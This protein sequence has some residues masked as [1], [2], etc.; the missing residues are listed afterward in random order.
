M[1]DLTKKLSQYMKPGTYKKGENITINLAQFDGLIIVDKGICLVETSRES[2][3]ARGKYDVSVGVLKPEGSM[4]GLEFFFVPQTLRYPASVRSVTDSDVRTMT[5]KKFASLLDT[6]LASIKTFIFEEIARQLADYFN[7]LQL[8]LE[9]Q[10]KAAPE[11]R[12]L[13]VFEH[14]RPIVGTPHPAG[15]EIKIPTYVL[16]RLAGDSPRSFQEG[17]KRLMQEGKLLKSGRASW[18][19]PTHN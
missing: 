9:R 12:V 18:V 10:A 11:D 1:S 7:S 3:K 14:V 16:Q 15:T 2:A 4:I 13:D 17:A 19:L 6:E 5:R 8:Q